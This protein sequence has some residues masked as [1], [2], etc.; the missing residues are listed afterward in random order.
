MSDTASN[1][2]SIRTRHTIK[3]LARAK[4]PMHP[5]EE[6]VAK[7][8]SIK[9]TGDQSQ[10]IR[11]PWGNT[12]ELTGAN[13]VISPTYSPSSLLRLPKENSILDQCIRAYVTNIDSFGYRLEYI[14]P[15]GEQESREAVIEKESIDS[16]VQQP[17]SDYTFT[18]LRIRLRTDME[19]FGYAFMEVG[20]DDQG[21]VLFMHHVPAQ[22]IRMTA[23]QQIAVD[24][25]IIFIRG[26][27]RISQTVRSYYRKFIQRAGARAIYFK[28]F[29]DPRTMNARSGQ[30]EDDTALEDQSTEILHFSLYAPGEA[31]GLPRWINQIPSILGSRET[32][33]TNL[34]FFKKNG[35]PAMAIM[36]AGGGLTDESIENIEEL[37]A[38]GLGRDSIHKV[39]VLEAKGD[40]A[41]SSE[42]GSLPIP[43][44]EMKPLAQERQEDGLFLQY[45]EKSS[46][47]IRSSFRLPPLYLGRS[48]DL[49]WATAQASIAVTEGQVFA[50]ERAIFDD[51]VNRKILANENG[52][53]PIYWRFRTLPPRLSNAQQLLEA[54]RTLGQE[55]GT[56]P[57]MIIGFANEYFGLGAPMV[58]EAWGNIPWRA[59]L[60]LIRAGR[61]EIVNGEFVTVAPDRSSAPGAPQ[62]SVPTV[63]EIDDNEDDE[64]ND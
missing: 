47:K 6:E 14:G 43:R 26:G 61:L 39:L 1:V 24:Q 13:S 58:S 62:P 15:S 17:N 5:I 28:E 27:R 64:E 52:L 32:E 42:T 4:L 9:Q 11:D 45:E 31:Y 22:S 37:F 35:I 10:A 18:T 46:V 21:R 19:T 53:P 60:E 41:A 59:T 49:T 54:I 3:G 34:D 56:T 7:A 51:T 38:Q 50:P 12:A 25:P 33:L 23:V 20:R 55:G 63:I 8:Y 2:T 29:G 40:P 30:Y 36:V 48:E 44:L 57:N 16:L